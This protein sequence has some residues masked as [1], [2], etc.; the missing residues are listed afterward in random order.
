MSTVNATAVRLPQFSP[1]QPLT[2]FRRAERHFKLKKITNT[3]TQADYTFESLPE[4]VFQQIAPWLDTQAA[5]IHYDV[6]KTKL[7]REF[8]PTPAVRAHRIV[9]L[10]SQISH[11]RTPTQVWHE[12]NTLQQLPEKDSNGDY[13]QLNLAKEIW[14]MCLAPHVRR[15][16]INTE[17][18]MST[19]VDEADKMYNAH[20]AATQ[21]HH[22]PSDIQHP[23]AQASTDIAAVSKQSDTHRARPKQSDNFICWYHTRYGN[24]AQKC[25]EGC[26]YKPKNSQGGCVT[27]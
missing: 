7:L 9:N 6:L 3:A 12:I 22:S 1:N 8:C 21:L 14:L 15:G 10:P 5:E 17:G 24:K 26:Q 20:Q 13:K 16:L 2:W 4:F 27:A 18:A 25:I 23:I 19:L 11:D